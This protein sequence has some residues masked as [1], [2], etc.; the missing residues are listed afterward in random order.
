M[1]LVTLTLSTSTPPPSPPTTEATSIDFINEGAAPLGVYWVDFDGAEVLY[2][3]LAPQTRAHQP[4]YVG[5]VWR[6]RVRGEA[7]GWCA[8][9]STPAECLADPRAPLDDE[10]MVPPGPSR[11]G[12]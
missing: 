2:T 7:L 1:S 12:T 4:T 3:T 9:A 10:P 5:H 6:L 11:R 8:A